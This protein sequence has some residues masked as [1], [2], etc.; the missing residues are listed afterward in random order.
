MMSPERTVIL[1]GTSHDQNDLAPILSVLTQAFERSGAE[2][3]TITL[4]R[5]KLAHCI[6]C[7][8][9]W[10]ETPGICIAADSG[11]DFAAAV[12]RSRTVVLFTPVT[13]GGYSSELKRIVD[14]FVQLSLPYFGTYRGETHHPSRYG[15]FP[16]LVVVGVQRHANPGEARVFKGVVGRNAINFHAPSYAVE[17]VASTDSLIT[18]RQRFESLLVRSDPLPLDETIEQIM[19]TPNA[20]SARAG[21]NGAHRALLI[22]GSPKTKSPST[23]GVLG[24]YLLDRLKERGW[25]TESLTLQA[26]LRQEAGQTALCSAV[27]R[28][29]LLLL[30]FPLYIDAL[31]FLMTKA[32]EVIALHRQ[33]TAVVRPQRLVAVCNSGFPEAGQSRMALAICHQFAAQCGMTWAGGLAMGSGD[34]LCDGQSLTATHRPGSPPVKHV[35]HALDMT[36]AALAEGRPV[37]PEAVAMIAQSP[38]PFAPSAVWRWLF[39]KVGDHRWLQQAAGNGLDRKELL[40]RPYAA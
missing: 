33:A 18:L 29:D 2:V 36:G 9:C 26:N 11:R 17:V 24:G 14:R 28:A 37:P 38:I 5:A 7:F 20:Q 23:S 30:A 1:D 40:A 15:R 32:M 8:G 31:P 27:D 39:M 25:D 10:V 3:E 35:V 12:I 19:P 22:V 13:C 34:A 4:R 21:S 6:G 16:R